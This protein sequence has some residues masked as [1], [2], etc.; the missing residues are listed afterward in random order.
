MRWNH[1]FAL[2]SSQLLSFFPVVKED[3]ALAVFFE[4]HLIWSEVLTL[5]RAEKEW[6]AGRLPVKSLRV[7]TSSLACFCHK[8]LFG[9][10]LIALHSAAQVATSAQLGMLAHKQHSYTGVWSL[11][12]WCE[13]YQSSNN[14]RSEKSGRQAQV[15][16]GVITLITS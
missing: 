13:L 2:K 4:R 16:A 10:D 5:R 7:S 3:S 1:S 6:M 15:Y 11:R 12:F 8:M 14:R 9:P